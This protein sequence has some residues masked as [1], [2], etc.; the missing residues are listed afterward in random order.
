MRLSLAAIVGLVALVLASLTSLLALGGYAGDLTRSAISADVHLHSFAVPGSFRVDRNELSES[1]LRQIEERAAT[2]V[3]LRMSLD[4][5]G[6]KQL[7]DLIIP[8]LINPS[9]V[10]RLIQD[11]PALSAI[12]DI[13]S[14]KSVAEIV[15]SNN[16]DGS[17]NDAVVLLPGLIGA[18]NMAGVPVGV[19]TTEPGL[20]ALSLGTLTAG[21]SRALT[22]WMNL[23]VLELQAVQSKIR[24]GAAD[25]LNGQVHMFGRTDWTGR[26]LEVLP[27]TRWI[28]SFV[29]AFCGLSA[30]GALLVLMLR[31]RQRISVAG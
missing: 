4:E 30:L 18:Q 9:V 28:V 1:L 25:G 19:I 3:G 10:A 14:Y 29:V 5:L 23:S 13:S 24:V 7:T 27:W 6:R 16:T 31:A 2:D 26:D 22:V 12:L 15:V 8:R 17:L 20:T 11:V 21:E